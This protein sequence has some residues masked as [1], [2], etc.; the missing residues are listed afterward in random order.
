MIRIAISGIAGRMG[1]S[2]VSLVT[3]FPNVKL[4]GGTV[5][6]GADLRAISIAGLS[7]ER[8]SG[9][10]VTERL[11]DLLDKTDVVVDFTRPQTT[12]QNARL[13][14]GAGR[15]IVVGTTGL[16]QHQLTELRDIAVQI[17]VF[18]APNMSL[19]IAALHATLPLLMDLLGDYDVEIIE[20]HHRNKVDAPS[21]TALGLAE[22]VP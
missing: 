21:G 22:S 16:D 19:G 8:N 3:D 20:T 7:T 11:E 9:G 2:I 13:C 1:R 14:V 18:Y 17:P 4:I 15:A 6:P 5:R 12:M 10:H